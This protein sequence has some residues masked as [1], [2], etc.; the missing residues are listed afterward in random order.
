MSCLR[1]GRTR[2]NVRGILLCPSKGRAVESSFAKENTKI[3]AAGGVPV[4]KA[5][6]PKS[7]KSLGEL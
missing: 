1:K 2:C 3:R 6:M 5:S 4:K 7:V